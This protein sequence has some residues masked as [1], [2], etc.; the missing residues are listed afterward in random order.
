MNI[1]LI[2]FLKEFLL[3]II[4]IIFVYYH[5]EINYIVKINRDMTGPYNGGGGRGVVWIKIFLTSLFLPSDN[6]CP[7]QSLLHILSYVLLKIILSPVIYNLAQS[8]KIAKI[9]AFKISLGKMIVTF[10][11]NNRSLAVP[12]ISGIRFYSIKCLKCHFLC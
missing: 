6:I 12:L 8:V 11:Q 9:N 2:D 4:K 5:Y 3:K 7:N 1:H 10:V